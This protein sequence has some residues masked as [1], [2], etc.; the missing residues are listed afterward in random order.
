MSDLVRNPNCLLS[1]V[2]AQLTVI[3]VIK[4]QL[5]RF[6]LVFIFDLYG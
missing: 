4:F 1:Q 6:I 5:V 2:N 3:K